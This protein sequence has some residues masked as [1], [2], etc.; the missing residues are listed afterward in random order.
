MEEAALK[1][2]NAYD[3]STSF[4]TADLTLL[5]CS[6]SCSDCEIHGYVYIHSVTPLNRAIVHCAITSPHMLAQTSRCHNVD[7]FG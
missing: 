6:V 7:L 4:K 2:A 5:A 1:A 3:F